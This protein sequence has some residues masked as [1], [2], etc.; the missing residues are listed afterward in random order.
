M[1]NS[2]YQS[3]MGG[4]EI[5]AA[6]FVM[7]HFL[8]LLA[9][10]NKTSLPQKFWQ[11]KEYQQLWKRHVRA[12]HAR[13]KEYHAEAIV[14]GLQ[15]K[16]L[17][18]LRSLNNAASWLWKPVFDKYQQIVEEEL[19]QKEQ[20]KNREIDDVDISKRRTN[21]QPSKLDKLRDLDNA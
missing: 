8:L 21:T 16:K 1:S 18:R 19:K 7:E 2:K 14:R 20:Y 11:L 17:Q 6:Q 4:G 13:L 3:A 15:D 10:Q 9:K 5:T 12:V